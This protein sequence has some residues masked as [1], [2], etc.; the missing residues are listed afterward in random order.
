ML[1]VL[2]DG[3]TP[4]SL[5]A[6]AALEIAKHGAKL[7]ILAGRTLEKLQKTQQTIQEAAPTVETRLLVLDLASQK[8]VRKAAEEVNSYSEPIN[9][10]INSGMYSTP[11][12][13]VQSGR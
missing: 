5:G 8:Q 6:E 13:L 2:I 4:G 3:V 7:L 12:H 11:L 9:V 10:V 1:L